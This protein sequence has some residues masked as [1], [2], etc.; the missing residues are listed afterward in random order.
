MSLD[1]AGPWTHSPLPSQ[2]SCF[3]FPHLTHKTALKGCSRY[4]RPHLMGG[5]LGFRQEKCCLVNS[6]LP[7][8]L[9]PLDSPLTCRLE[10]MTS[11]CPGKGSGLNKTLDCLSLPIPLHLSP[12]LRL[13][14][15]LRLS[16]WSC[17]RIS[18]RCI[19]PL[20]PDL[21]PVTRSGHCVRCSCDRPCPGQLKRHS[22]VGRALPGSCWR[23]GGSGR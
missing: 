21:L 15:S 5:G 17:R 10:P 12:E 6:G 4:Q 13:S 1:L 9:Q 16:R 20:T 14:L 3:T 19:T 11:D 7:L 8:W 18:L 23:W 22:S 2:G